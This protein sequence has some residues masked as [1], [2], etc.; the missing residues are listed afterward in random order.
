MEPEQ[1]LFRA[2]SKSTLNPSSATNENTE[3]QQR[4]NCCVKA[5]DQL[6][7]PGQGSETATSTHKGPRRTPRC[8]REPENTQQTAQTDVEM[9]MTTMIMSGGGE[10]E[11][12]RVAGTHS[13]GLHLQASIANKWTRHQMCLCVRAPKNGSSRR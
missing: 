4:Q 9:A 11:R 12:R 7:Q 8:H 13:S 10:G 5:C 2:S 3:W 6:V 1:S